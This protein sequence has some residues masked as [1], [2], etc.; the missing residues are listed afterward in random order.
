M[1]EY[2]ESL[3]KMQGLFARMQG[4]MERYTKD[5]G[6][7]SRVGK[8]LSGMW[9]H[10]MGMA[11]LVKLISTFAEIHPPYRPRQLHPRTPVKGQSI[12]SESLSPLPSTPLADSPPDNSEVSPNRS[13]RKLCSFKYPHETPSPKADLPSII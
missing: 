9:L 11:N 4:R 10:S 3:G 2:S 13:Y 12:S 1:S 5:Y 6:A 8:H 7:R